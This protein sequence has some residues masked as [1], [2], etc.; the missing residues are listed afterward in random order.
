MDTSDALVIRDH[1]LVP[2]EWTTAIAMVAHAS[3]VV[4]IRGESG[5]GKD[6]VARLIHAATSRG[7]F[8]KVNCATRPTDVLE[9]RLFGHARHPNLGRRRIGAFE[10]AERGTLYLDDVGALPP[11]LHLDVLRALR[12]DDGGRGSPGAPGR[13]CRVILATRQL[14]TGNARGIPPWQASALKLL[15]LH[16]PALRDRA[17][18]IAPL[19]RFFLARFNDWYG[20]DVGLSEDQLALLERYSWPENVR[21]LETLIRDLVVRP[22]PERLLR[23][24]R[25]AI[26]RTA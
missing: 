23:G 13:E 10:L 25:S 26:R 1:T 22:D 19:A 7:P 5:T 21:E 4:L 6:V 20:R 18:H 11:T 8:V 2:V 12:P 16:L 24:I 17:T 9:T 14:L 3:D 15:D